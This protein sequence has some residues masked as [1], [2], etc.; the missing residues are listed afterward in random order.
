MRRWTDDGMSPTRA[1]LLSIAVTQL[2]LIGL[3]ATFA[4]LGGMSA[5]TLALLVGALLLPSVIWFGLRR[6]V[7]DY[8]DNYGVKDELRRQR[9]R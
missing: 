6:A 7:F 5:G 9:P 4:L 2:P 1:A 8:M 3:L